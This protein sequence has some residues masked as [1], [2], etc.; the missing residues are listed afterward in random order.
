MRNCC[1][2]AIV[3]VLLFLGGCATYSANHADNNEQVDLYLSTLDDKHFVWCEL[4]LEQCRNDFEEWKLTYRGQ[5][6]IRE[7]E[8]ADTGQTYNRHSAP[9][10]F[11]AHFI[12]ERLLAGN[13]CESDEGKIHS[14]S[15]LGQQENHLQKHL[16]EPPQLFGPDIPPNFDSYN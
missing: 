1:A 4:D 6:I 15:S 3:S 14:P 11:H 7:Y 13:N 8:K 10:V 12:D 5:K 9:H 2:M 16:A